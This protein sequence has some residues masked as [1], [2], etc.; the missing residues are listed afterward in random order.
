M[1]S[2]PL[3]TLEAAN[4][5]VGNDPTASNHI[6]LRNL[7]FPTMEKNFVE[8]TPGGGVVGLEVDTHFNRIEVTFSLNG[9]TPQVMSQIGLWS[10]QAQQFS[11]Y[12]MLRN[13]LSGEAIRVEAYIN[14]MLS[15]MAPDAFEKGALANIEYA[16][17]AVTFYQLLVDKTEIYRWDMANNEMLIGGI[18]VMADQNAMLNIATSVAAT[19]EITNPVTQ[20]IQV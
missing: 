10:R 7:K 1:A 20:T 17:R 6:T 5:F 4:I 16:I 8:F 2:N 3:L 18:D 13:R 15:R 9:W 19:A 11:L 14:G 12:G